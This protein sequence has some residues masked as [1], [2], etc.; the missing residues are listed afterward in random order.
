MEWRDSSCGSAPSDSS[1]PSP[2]ALGLCWPPLA[3][4]AQQPGKI[5]HIGVLSALFPP[6]EPDWQQ[7]SPSFNPSGKACVSW[8]GWRDRTW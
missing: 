1:S 7:R 5:Y 8:G 4:D 3:A 6:V 2:G